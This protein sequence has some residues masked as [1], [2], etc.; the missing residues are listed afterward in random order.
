[1]YTTLC[2][3][4]KI[5]YQMYS[6]Y[7][8]EMPNIMDCYDV[9]FQFITPRRKTL[10]DTGIQHERNLITASDIWQINVSWDGI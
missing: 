10:C 9:I 6:L 2:S 1:M 3:D 4:I 8:N 7:T 5:Q